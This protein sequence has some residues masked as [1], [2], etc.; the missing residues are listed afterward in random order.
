MG[1]AGRVLDVIAPRVEGTIV[2][3]GPLGGGDVIQV[4]DLPPDVAAA[5]GINLTTE[6]VTRRQAMSLPT[7]AQGRMQIAGTI[8]TFPLVCT[9]TVAG[10]RTLV[11]R[12]LLSRPDPDAT[13]QH[14][15]TWTIDDLMFSGIAWWQITSRDTTRWPVTAR[16]LH[17]SRVV[18]DVTRR[19]VRV[20]G[21]LV[22]PTDLIRFDAPHEG[23]LR[24]GARILRTALLLEEAVRRYAVMDI[25][26][27]N[28]KDTRTD[29]RPLTP[30]EIRERL[31]TWLDARRRSNTG[32]L[33]PNLEYQPVQFNARELQLVE[34]RQH[35]AIELARLM[36]L[37]ADAVN[38]PAAS[39]MTYQNGVAQ[40]R[41]RLDMSLRHYM[42]AITDR[43]SMPDVTPRTQVVTYD[44]TG[45]LRGDEADQVNTATTA[46]GGPVMT[47]DE[48]RAAYLNLPIAQ[49]AQP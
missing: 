47:V 32:W 6:S 12:S 17:P 8:G 40:R 24:I 3:T 4:A 14:T 39:P 1:I 34:A 46:A 20:D 7:V 44:V 9:Q 16:R 13:Y 38:A 31:Q 25:P 19:Q 21:D 11:T 10:R 30:D 15:L 49:E 2:T 18:V 33:S 37:D 28:L 43:L 41:A 26:I 23:L 29:G 36:N 42:T 35:T 5:F 45:W 48:A 22:D 27:G